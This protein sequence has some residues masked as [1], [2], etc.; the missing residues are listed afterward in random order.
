TMKLGI[1]ALGLLAFAVP[2]AA[3]EKEDGKAVTVEFIKFKPGAAA[4]IDEIETKSF[5]PA[6]RK[7]GFSPLVVRFATGQWDREYIFPMPG[8]MADL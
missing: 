5:D 1:I 4:R 2:A 6:A 8:G 7:F 3:Q